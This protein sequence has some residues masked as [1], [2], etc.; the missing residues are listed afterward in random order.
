MIR[1]LFWDFF[2]VKFIKTL[3]LS[4]GDSINGLIFLEDVD[5]TFSP[6]GQKIRRALCLC[7][8]GN[9]ISVN[10]YEFIKGKCAS[11]C[12]CKEYKKGTKVF[13]SWRGMIGRCHP[14][15][16]QNKYYYK[17]GIAVC[18]EW[19]NFNAFEK[20]AINNGFEE[21][22]ELDRKNNSL[23]Y[24]PENCRFVTKTVNMRNRDTTFKCYIDGDNIAFMDL[25]ERYNISTFNIP[26]IYW[27]I[28]HGGW[29]TKKAFE[30]PVG[31]K[32]NTFKIGQYDMEDNLLNTFDNGC[33]AAKHINNYTS[34]ILLC[35]KGKMKSAGGFKWKYIKKD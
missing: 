2:I 33:I 20:W 12:G 31:F 35:C 21:G 29:E 14:A 30:T 16:S 17:K 4:K 18:L 25:C 28:K 10:F 22:L 6:S 34:T 1:L 26:A 23:G 19:K 8:C 24:Y 7:E 3:F 13:E 15:H 32:N 5:N 27:R 11:H 9:T